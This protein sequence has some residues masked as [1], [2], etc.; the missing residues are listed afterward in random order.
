M[1][2]PKYKWY[3]TDNEWASPWERHLLLS[4]FWTA[5]VLFVVCLSVFIGLMHVLS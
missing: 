5:V 1:K 2:K 3:K 4:S